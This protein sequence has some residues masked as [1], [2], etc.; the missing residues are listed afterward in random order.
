MQAMI[1]AAGFG[2]RLQP[3]SLV[4]PKP[5]FP[6]LNQPLLLA[7]IGRLKNA[8]FSTIVINCHHLG[9]QIISAVKDIP[10]V[11]IQEEERI[12]GTGG[13]LARAVR[14]LDETPLL[15][16][17]G[18]IYH[19]VDFA[20]LYHYHLQTDNDVTM[21]LHDYPRFNKIA[22]S[23][24]EIIDFNPPEEMRV[25]HAFTGI[26]VVNPEILRQLSADE[27]S[28]IIA[29]Y[30][31][32]LEAGRRISCRIDNRINW[33]DMGT[34]EDYLALHE[35]LLQGTMPRWAELKY[36]GA[37][38]FL[39][40]EESHCGRNCCFQRWVSIGKARIGDDVELK[41]CVVWDGAEVADGSRISD[42][43]IVSP[44]G[45]R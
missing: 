6:V 34:V 44:E 42:S 28:C 38:E 19:T 37:S 20:D 8:G 23:G 21:V 30:R 24:N 32:L 33:T 26:Q 35:A 11:V 27:Y 16:T 9:Q 45:L 18:D 5:L 29:H 40:D 36:Q 1:L 22:V 13:S 3:Y 15:V 17:N 12:L 43:I 31:F 2:T 41:R 7:T 25:L 14:S 10:G 39:V 4:R